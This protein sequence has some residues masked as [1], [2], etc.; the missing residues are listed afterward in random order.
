MFLKNV[1]GGIKSMDGFDGEDCDWEESVVFVGDSEE[2]TNAKTKKI[3]IT[4]ISF[5]FC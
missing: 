2:E 3:M 4:I 5:Y 1:G